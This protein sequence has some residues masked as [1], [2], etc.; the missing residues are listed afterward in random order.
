LFGYKTQALD[1]FYNTYGKYLDIASNHRSP[2]SNLME[3]KVLPDIPI[4]LRN[5][6]ESQ[7]AAIKNVLRYETPVDKQRRQMWQSA[8][9]AVL[10]D[11]TNAARKLAHDA[12]WW[13]KDKNPIS[14]I[15]G[16][17]FDMKLGIWNPG[18]LLIQSSTMIS[19][20]ALSPKYGLKGMAGLFPMHAYLLSRGSE[21]VLDTLVK[22]GVDKVMGF[23]SF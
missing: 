13:W 7:R 21:N 3:S 23:A 9:E 20:T 8:A 12:V 15:R 16:L 22:R 19:A 10:G 5:Q 2:V 17:A 14:F 11:G 4:E 6:I 1:R 18:Q